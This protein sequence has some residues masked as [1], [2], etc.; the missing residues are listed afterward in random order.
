M[1]GWSMKRTLINLARE[2]LAWGAGRQLIVRR[3]CLICMIIP[4]V[5]VKAIIISLKNIKLIAKTMRLSTHS[6]RD[7]H[8]KNLIVSFWPHLSFFGHWYYPTFKERNVYPPTAL[9]CSSMYI[10]QCTVVCLD[11]PR[12]L[13][14]HATAVPHL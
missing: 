11:M 14:P 5:S 12:H 1:I 7:E 6:V 3:K 8:L 4:N 9:H 2:K 13:K 10:V